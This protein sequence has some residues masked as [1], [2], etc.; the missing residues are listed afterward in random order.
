MRKAVNGN[1]D[2]WLP[3]GPAPDGDDRPGC[4]SGRVPCAKPVISKGYPVH[5]HYWIMLYPACAGDRS[6]PHRYRS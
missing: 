1:A 3:H 4:I 6:R 5:M 2:W